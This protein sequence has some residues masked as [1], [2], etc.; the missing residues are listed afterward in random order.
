M[1]FF[2]RK[3]WSYISL[4][5]FRGVLSD[6][7][8]KRLLGK[9]IYIYPFKEKNLQ[10]ASYD[11]TASKCAFIMEDNTQKLIVRDDN[12]IIPARKTAIIESNESIYVRKR[13]TGTYHSLVGLTNQGLGHIS[14]TLDPGFF[15]LSAISLQNNTDEDIT[16]KVGDRIATLIFYTVKTVGSG[17]TCSMSGHMNDGIKIDSNNFYDFNNSSNKTAIILNCS[18]TQESE[19][20][21]IENSIVNRNNRISKF[22]FIYEFVMKKFHE[23]NNKN[24]IIF[25]D[26]NY[27]CDKC[28][29]CNDNKSCNYKIL[30]NERAEEDKRKKIIEELRVWKNSEYIQSKEFLIKKVEEEVI[31]RDIPKDIFLWSLILIGLGVGIGILVIRF[32]NSWFHLLGGSDNEK[33]SCIAT[34]ISG[35]PTA[36]ALLIAVMTN[37][38]LKIKK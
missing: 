3:L 35:I 27:S 26:G 12:I 30:K 11:L 18:E 8:I 23:R 38:K 21:Y 34:I 37:Y 10:S 1:L 13:I 36:V 25:D 31:E 16:I 6:K 20:E 7:D 17:I 22:N 19:N 15:G 28:V 2:F 4:F 5:L 14:T 24:V 29:S 33:A 9:Q 32:Q